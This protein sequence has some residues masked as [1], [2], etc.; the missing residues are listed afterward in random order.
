ML[1]IEP[2]ESALAD[3]LMEDIEYFDLADRDFVTICEIASATDVESGFVTT[4]AWLRWTRLKARLG[5]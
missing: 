3:N 4:R 2:V 5:V 1:H